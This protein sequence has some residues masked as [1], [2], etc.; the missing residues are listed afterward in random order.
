M[1]LFILFIY[2]SCISYH[3]IYRNNVKK[4]IVKN[5]HQGTCG[6]VALVR[7]NKIK[8]VICSWTNEICAN[9][10]FRLKLRKSFLKNEI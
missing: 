1:H 5:L 7:N 6:I 4:A 8:D 3:A 10:N 2:L 9:I